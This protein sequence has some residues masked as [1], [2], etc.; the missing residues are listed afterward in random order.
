MPV[1]KFLR[2]A[3]E[4]G[5]IYYLFRVYG[6][7]LRKSDFEH[8]GCSKLYERILL[9]GLIEEYG[10]DLDPLVK[11]TEKGRSYIISKLE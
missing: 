2:E 8:S 9:E 3:N 7:L 10:D 11:P 6:D 5:M 1:E 4:A